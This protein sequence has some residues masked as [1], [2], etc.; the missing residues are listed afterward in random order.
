MRKK[1]CN[2]PKLDLVNMKAYI[3]FG[4]NL[5]NCSQDIELKQNSGENQGPFPLNIL[6]SN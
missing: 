6:R 5:S 4:E 1:M 2:N 3:R